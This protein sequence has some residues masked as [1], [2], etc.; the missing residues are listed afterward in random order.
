MLTQGMLGMKNV[1]HTYP[2]QGCN[3]WHHDETFMDIFPD[4]YGILLNQY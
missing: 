4:T 1:L 3:A 2:K